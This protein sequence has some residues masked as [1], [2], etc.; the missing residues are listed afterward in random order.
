[1]Y[2]PSSQVAI[3]CTTLLSSNFTYTPAGPYLEQ[4]YTLFQT[5]Y[6]P[7]ELW[8]SRILVAISHPIASDKVT[9]PDMQILMGLLNSFAKV[10]IPASLQ[11]PAHKEQVVPIHSSNREHSLVCPGKIR[12]R[13]VGGSGVLHRPPPYPAQAYFSLWSLMFILDV[14]CAKFAKV[15]SSFIPF[16]D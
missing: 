6:R 16:T 13:G 2:N 4:R 3:T 12:S 14:A 9:L 10:S 1:M 11:V 8:P 7:P 5:E 15:N